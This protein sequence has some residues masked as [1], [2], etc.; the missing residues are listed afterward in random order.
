MRDGR[1]VTE[2]GQALDVANVIWCTGYRPGF[3]WIDLPV[4]GDRQEPQH[5]RGVVPQEPGLYFVGLE[6]LFSAS[7]ATIT[8]ASGGSSRRVVKHLTSR[9]PTDRGA[10]ASA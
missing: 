4:L 1:P 5:E 2:D 6:F 7:S 8:G 9:Q 3:S 10:L